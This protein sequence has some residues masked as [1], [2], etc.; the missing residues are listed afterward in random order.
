MLI[1]RSLSFLEVL[2]QPK[3]ARAGISDTSQPLAACTEEQKVAH[4]A[5]MEWGSMTCPS[6]SWRR[7]LKL[8]CRTPGVP[9]VMVAACF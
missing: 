6:A 3:Q 4:P 5:L 7:R 1:Y 9:L 2:S 8:P